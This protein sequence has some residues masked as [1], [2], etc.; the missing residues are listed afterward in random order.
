MKKHHQKTDKKFPFMNRFLSGLVIALA[1]TL[2]AFEWTTVTSEA[3][4][5]TRLTR[6]D[7]IEEMLP[8]ITYRPE[9]TKKVLP[10]KPSNQVTI[11][12]VIKPVISDLTP[13]KNEP[14]T[15]DPIDLPLPIIEPSYF[16]GEPAVVDDI[17]YEKVQVFAHYK[18]CSGLTGSE[19]Q[20]CSQQD[21][22][23]RIVKN[24]R[25]TPELNAIGDRQGA[26]LSFLIDNQGNIS[27][28]KVLQSTSIAMTKAAIKAIEKLPKVDFP[29]NQ[30]GRDV[31]L[32]MSI[33]IILNFQ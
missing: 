8:P 6:A 1:L 7:D 12:E 9:E 16:G 32:R 28:I 14:A 11:V 22:Q 33:P 19:L 30:Q 21:I 27:E 5:E 23:Q 18:N 13:K 31:A 10:K 25:T 2:T 17:I 29:A 20:A 15:T 24:F 4:I 3:I 26:L